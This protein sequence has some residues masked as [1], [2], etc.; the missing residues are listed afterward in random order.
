MT[1]KNNP[2]TKQMIEAVEE[3]G[4]RSRSSQTALNA[5]KNARSG[6]RN[7]SINR[8]TSREK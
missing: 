7:K 6:I 3:N 1:K 5:G 2:K 8:Y 4:W